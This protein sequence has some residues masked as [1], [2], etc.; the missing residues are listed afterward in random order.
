MNI[1]RQYFKLLLINKNNNHK[2]LQKAESVFTRFL[3]LNLHNFEQDE[4][5]NDINALHYWTTQERSV[6]SGNPKL[7]KYATFAKNKK[8]VL[9]NYSFGTIATIHNAS[10]KL[11]TI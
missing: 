2:T 6:N 5:F 9:T 10:H 8:D 7:L 4:L 3:K 1:L 11:H